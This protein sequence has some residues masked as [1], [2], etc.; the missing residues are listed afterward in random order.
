M[1]TSEDQPQTSNYVLYE[2]VPPEIIQRFD[3]Y[4]AFEDS[5]NF[6]VYLKYF[7]KY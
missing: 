7:E 4:L 6:Q 5:S 3:D 1:E 2:C